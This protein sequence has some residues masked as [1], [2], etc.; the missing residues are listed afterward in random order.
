M[1]T[2]PPRLARSAALRLT[3]LG[4]ALA[5]AL[6]PH[7]A[8]AATLRVGPGRP[9]TTIAAAVTAA[10]SGDVLSI[11]AG[12]Y[13]GI[14]TVE[15]KDLQLIGVGLVTWEDDGDSLLQVN[16]ST[17][18]VQN[19][20]FRPTDGRG[21]RAD[22]G[23]NVTLVDVEI[24]GS[25]SD[26]NG[27]AIAVYG[28]STVTAT[29]CL[30]SDNTSIYR[31]FQSEGYGGHVTVRSGTFVVSDST[32]IAGSA[33]LGGAIYMDS[34]ATVT[35]TRTTFTDHDAA[36]GGV[37]W[38]SDEVDLTVTDSTI[39][40]ARATSNGG[41]L[42]WESG[43]GTVTFDH[44]TVRDAAA[45]SY[46]GVAALNNAGSLQLLD[47]TFDTIAAQQGG[48]LSIYASD[49]FTARRNRFC[50][51]R[52]ADEG[53]A[54][55]LYQTGTAE[56]TNNVFIDDD[57]TGAAFGTG[58]GGAIWADD[59]DPVTLQ[60]NDF[61]D[62]SANGAAG[63][64][65]ISATPSTMRNNLIA[66]TQDGTALVSTNGA[67]VD[68][69]YASF[70]GNLGGDTNGVARGANSVLTAPNL[71]FYRRNNICGDDDLRPRVGSPL[72]DAGDPSILDPDGSRSD[73][74]AF[75]GPASDPE[76]WL[77]GDGDG[78]PYVYDCDDANAA[79]RPGATE[80]CNGVDDDCDFQVDINV[81]GAPTWY[82]DGDG[83][84]FGGDAGAFTACETPEDATSTGGDC[85]DANAD[86]N[87]TAPEICDGL[88]NDCDGVV[89]GPDPVD[90]QTF[91]E[92]GDGDG[93]G[94]LASPLLACSPP[95]GWVADASDCDDTLGAVHPGV[96]EVCNGL[97]DNCD[98]STDGADAID[99]LSWYADGDGDG[100]GAPGPN[101]TLA[102]SQPADRVRTDDDCDDA[103]ADVYPR[104]P[105]SCTDTTDRNCDGLFGDVDNDGDGFVACEDCDDADPN[106][107]PGAPD[108]PYDGQVTDCDSPSDFDADRD[109][110]ESAAYGGTDCDDANPAI[111][112]AAEEI[113]GDEVDSDCDGDPGTQPD[114]SGA[115]DLR[116]GCAGCAQGQAP[117]APG[118]AGLLALAT[119][120]RGRRRAAR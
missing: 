97:D 52:A 6:A 101:T 23:A 38:G 87:P 20:V 16:D 69:D 115:E 94:D 98:G 119:L 43:Q 55:R 44:V 10:R 24:S 66:W 29:G 60:N 102:C 62:S 47:S 49:P 76:A 71:V 15:G 88:D 110:F 21:I 37:F 56:L 28:D 64:I 32:F 90:P 63:A 3:C 106:A 58:D 68:Q 104:A 53:G 82:P 81:V 34:G 57:A 40:D 46:G 73:I 95:E 4:G 36:S 65:R 89:D 5:M 11:D 84:G 75:G 48:S 117:A 92:D 111:S 27:A 86:V 41:V 45:S 67:A 59:T 61:L 114:L 70:W 120:W 80:T 42:R 112:P 17:V 107:Y 116:I 12:S 14:V 33:Q 78:S 7:V 74:G 26:F 113:F 118:V 39:T 85:D 35:V 13:G 103:D 96:D 22:E 25:N 18:T 79:I 51:S 93:F 99:A 9:Y 91:Y 2:R 19:I 109:G 105:E 83:D 8:H 54:V 100:F 31:F 77:D 30:F 50:A 108:V 72:I 1:T